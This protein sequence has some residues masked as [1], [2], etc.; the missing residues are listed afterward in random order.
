MPNQIESTPAAIAATLNSVN[1]TDGTNLIAAMTTSQGEIVRITNED[2]AASVVGRRNAILLI[3]DGQASCPIA[4][5]TA[6]RT[7]D[8]GGTIF[9][10]KTYVIGFGSGVSASCLNSMAVAG[11]TERCQLGDPDCTYQYYTADN[12][13]ELQVAM[14]E[15]LNLATAEECNGLDDDC[16]GQIDEGNPGGG[17]A[18]DTGNVGV[19]QAGQWQCLNGAL[20]CEQ[21]V[22]PSAEVCNGMDDDCDGEV[23]EGGVCNQPPVA[24][25]QDVTIE[26]GAGCVGCASI[27]SGSYDPDGPPWTVNETPGCDYPLGQ[28]SASLTIT[29]PW[30]AT[31]TC[32]ATVNVVDTTAPTVAC[33]AQA[34]ITPPDAPITFTATSADV[35]GSTA[36]VVSY[37][38]WAINGAGKR[39]DKKQSCVVSF[40]GD[41]LTI[42]DSGGIGDNIEWVVEGTDGSGNTT[43]VTCHLEVV[44]KK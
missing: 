1:P 18:C 20:Q 11:G 10:V 12:S 44:K 25:C 21:V 38:C 40:S 13:T 31:D 34:T 17:G 19:C 42:A 43:S 15:I 5:V 8:V 9:D 29:D 23:D 37:D 36:Q 6:L 35:C 27:D 22:Q 2:I 39:I 14:T 3:T 30:G 4:Q 28:T 16:D 7:L 41:Q 26:A 24:L 33:N 32:A